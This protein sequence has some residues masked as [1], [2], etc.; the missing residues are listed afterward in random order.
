MPSPGG[1][2]LV[3][4]E[5]ELSAVR[6]AVAAAAAGSGSMLMIEGPAG[7]GKSRLLREAVRAAAD[8][9]IRV[10]EARGGVMEQELAYGA[11]RLLLERPL[12]ALDEADRA[13]VLSDAAA[14]AAPAL[15]TVGAEPEVPEE[16]SFAVMHGLFWTIANLAERGPLLLAL[17]DVHWFDAPSVRFLHYLARRVSDLPVAML[18]ASRVDEPS[19]QQEL[20]QQLSVEAAAETLRPAP[21]STAGVAAVVADA[22]AATVEPA[23][24]SACHTAV[25][26]NPFLLTELVA[27]LAAEGVQ[28]DAAGAETVRAVR[29]PTVARAVLLRL[30]RMPPGSR[31]LATAVAVL[32]DGGGTHLHPARELA[33]VDAATATAALDGLVRAGILVASPELTF[34]HPI[35]RETVYRELGPAQRAG[36]HARAAEL[37]IA[38]GGAGAAERAAPHLLSTAPGGLQDTVDA[39]RRAARGALDRGAP[40]IATRYLERALDE[41]P[42]LEHRVPTLLDLAV[43]GLLAGQPNPRAKGQVREAIGLIPDPAARARA[44]MLLAHLTLLDGGAGRVGAVLDEALENVG[45]DGGPERQ[46]LVDERDLFGSTQPATAVATSARLKARTPPAGDT[47]AERRLLCVLACHASNEGRDLSQAVELTERAFAGGQ[48]MADEGP[49]SIRL[50]HLFHAL[51]L[52]DLLDTA[53]H[54]LNAALTAG[55]AQG[56]LFALGVAKSS[57][58]HL[59]YLGGAVADAEADALEVPSYPWLEPFVTTNVCMPRL[60][61]GAFDEVERICVAVGCGPQMAEGFS[62]NDV[63]WVRGRLRAAQG[64]LSEALDDLLEFGRRSDRLLLAN[65]VYTWRAEAALVAARMEDHETARRLAAEYDDTARAWGTPRVL[66]ISARTRGLLAAG[67]TAWRCCARPW[68]PTRPRPHGWSTPG[69]RWSWGRRCAGQACDPRPSR[70]SPR[71]PSS[72]G[73]AA[74]PC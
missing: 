50:Y 39:L 42:A 20:L 34:A 30:A 11:L 61:R 24:G 3:E 58:A 31:E 26:G 70:C 29:P 63:F 19:G 27:A 32:G 5:A 7:I 15:A 51:V 9:G 56:S 22:M 45:T 33:G 55:R 44:W 71:P 67:A 40:D 72:R 21:L 35:V 28:P 6:A 41:P 64:R 66:G 8:H 17:D 57:R 53:A 74:R 60:E 12:A 10:L 37:I 13:D 43:T 49:T 2:A 52:A 46:A 59:H 65:P 4:R 36:W 68:P 14:L 69:P 62:R 16:R 25:G 38:R 54:L 18:V 23:F 47:A 1:P 48:V 73:A